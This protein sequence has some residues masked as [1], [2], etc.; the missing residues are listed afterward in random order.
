M[1]DGL[2]SF[3]DLLQ[4]IEVF[5]VG[6]E[7]DAV[8]LDDLVGEAG[9]FQRDVDRHFDGADLVATE[10]R[11]QEL[12]TVRQHDRDLVARLDAERAGSRS[13]PC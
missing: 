2:E 8:R 1:M 4:P 13:P 11:V 10:P 7:H 9:A 6:H 12:G 5:G 3:D